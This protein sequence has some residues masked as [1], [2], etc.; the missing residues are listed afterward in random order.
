MSA[1][2]LSRAIRA[3]SPSAGKPAGLAIRT[4]SALA[5]VTRPSCTWRCSIVTWR[6]SADEA[7]RSTIGISQSQFHNATRATIAATGIAINSRGLTKR[8][9]ATRPPRK[10]ASLPLFLL[11]RNDHDLKA[12]PG[13]D[14]L[15]PDSPVDIREKL[16]RGRLF[17]IA[18]IEAALRPATKTAPR[19][20]PDV[21]TESQ[22]G[23]EKHVAELRS[24]GPGKRLL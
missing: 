22:R 9:L 20:A 1:C 23:I 4:L 2:T 12:V 15:W 21:Q 19:S 11:W 17:V 16:A 3:K 10:P 13:C 5:T 6:P 7:R 14:R 8:P 18:H 24:A